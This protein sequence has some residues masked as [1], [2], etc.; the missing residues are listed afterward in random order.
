MRACPDAPAG[1]FDQAGNEGLSLP[2]PVAGDET[3]TRTQKRA[4]AI[5]ALAFGL[6]SPTSVVVGGGL[7]IVKLGYNQVP[8][9]PA[10]LAAGALLVS[11]ALI[12][13]AT[14]AGASP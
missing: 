7:A 14:L 11:V 4:L 13:A 12:I 9:L 1:G 6:I 3:L 2:G 5:T 10:A 8:A